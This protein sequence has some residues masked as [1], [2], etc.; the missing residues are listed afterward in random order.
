MASPPLSLLSP[1]EFS[2]GMFRHHST[3]VSLNFS[4]TFISLCLWSLFQIYLLI[5]E[6]SLQ[7][8][9]ISYLIHLLSFSFKFLCSSFLEILFG[10]FPNWFSQ[11]SLFLIL[12][13]FLI[14]SLITLD[15]LNFVSWHSANSAGLILLSVVSLGKCTWCFIYLHSLCIFSSEFMFLGSL[16][17]RILWDLNRKRWLDLLLNGISL[18]WWMLWTINSGLH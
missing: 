9:L 6:Y 1:L 8:C 2:W 4:H 7:L 11:S 16:Y 17:R 10:S 18:P 13:M 15:S 12:L 14:L 3:S 5:Y